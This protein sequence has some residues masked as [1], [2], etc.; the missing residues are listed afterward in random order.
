MTTKKATAKPPVKNSPQRSQTL[1]ASAQATS[2]L[3]SA[4]AKHLRT[5]QGS[6]IGKL[7]PSA[8]EV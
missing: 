5:R 3:R 4:H 1:S 7:K 2:A 6:G 8:V